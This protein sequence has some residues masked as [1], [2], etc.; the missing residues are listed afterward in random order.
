MDFKTNGLILKIRSLVRWTS[1]I[2]SL[3]SSNSESLKIGVWSQLGLQKP[4]PCSQFL[5]PILK[6]RSLVRWTLI[7]EKLNVDVPDP[8]AMLQFGIDVTAEIDAYLTQE[9]QEKNTIA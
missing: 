3:E 1:K 9:E 4:F 8:N 5:F 2:G 7:Y 6:I